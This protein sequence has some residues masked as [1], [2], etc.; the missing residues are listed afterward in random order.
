MRFKAKVICGF[1]QTWSNNL[2]C[3]DIMFTTFWKEN[4]YII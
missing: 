3:V 4:N 1:V 2:E